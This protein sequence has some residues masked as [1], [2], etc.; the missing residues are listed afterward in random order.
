MSDVLQS[1]AR[2]SVPVFIVSSMLTMG[3]GL[4]AREIISPLKNPRLVAVVLALNF[5]LAPGLAYLLTV[6]FPLE[7]PYA[8]G[9]ILLGCAAGAPFLPKLAQVARADL[10]LSV[11]LMAL[12]TVGTILFMPVALPVLAPG[13]EANRM[14]IARPL[15]ILMLLPLGAAMALR[16]GAPRFSE[17]C[18]PVVNS[19]AN[20]SM[21]VL[22]V[23]LIGLN[24]GALL[25]VV[26]SGAI[27]V[28]AVSV[29]LVFAAG[30][31]AGGSRPEVKGALGLA[32]AARNL[33]AAL[34]AAAAQPDPKILVMLLVGTLVGLVICLAAGV[35]LRRH[36]APSPRRIGQVIAMALAVILIQFAT[37]GCG[38]VGP[39]TVRHD[40]FNYT[41][42]LSDSWKEQMLVNMVK[43]RYGDTPVF[44][45]V[46]SVINQY[47]VETQVDLRMSWVDPVVSVGDSQSIG[48]SARYSDKPTITYMPLT[49]ER[50]ARSL[51]KPLP[52]PAVLSLIQAGYPVD[53]VL[54][55][56]THSV[57]G[58]RNRYGGSARARPADPEFFPIL[59]RLRRM[60]DSGAL[61][62]RVQKTNEMEGVVMTFRG[63]VDP[64][65]EEDVLFVRKSLGLDPAG[66]EFRVA[67][68]SI[69]KDDKEIAILSR[70]MLE[71]IIDLASYIEVPESHVRD[72]RC[73]PTMAQETNDGAPV[74]P[75]IGIHSGQQKPAGDLAF[76]AV[77]HRDYWYWI[78]DRDLRSKS[79]FT[80]LMF[81]LSLTETQGKEGAPIVTIP[82]G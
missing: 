71:I 4:T 41:E 50:F 16:S 78:D 12:L 81:M 62:L 22:L 63:K 15:L 27:A 82:A 65:L 39:R 37:S 34:P 52:P 33:G 75:L 54:R 21:V 31:T 35:V 9:L 51:M 8:V 57:N 36:T 45:D 23:L 53:V 46:A 77:K 20:A 11:S 17:M 14:A 56:C 79:L 58:I 6:V 67:Y 25:G 48:G 49:G 13:F 59:Q 29:G 19:I 74:P 80:F 32:S 42:A 5:V 30:Y 1:I 38:G 18:R 40:R 72:R 10:A 61:G 7:R 28:S 68:G 44:L 76:V 47:A 2:L 60:Q 26:G 43:L 64:A 70:S 24:T 73:A 66:Q 55:V 3:L 69:P